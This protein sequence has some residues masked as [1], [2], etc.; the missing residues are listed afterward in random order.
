MRVEQPDDGFDDRVIAAGLFH[1]Q[2]GNA[3]RRVAAGL[4]LRTVGVE[5]A[6][7]HV[8]MGVLGKLDDDELIAADAGAPVGN[9]ADLFRPQHE[10]GFAD[11]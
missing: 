3:A 11:V 1:H 4:D 7:E 6:H 8:G 9:S 2:I 10:A 5:N